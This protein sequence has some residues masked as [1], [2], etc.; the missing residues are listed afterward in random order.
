MPLTVISQLDLSSRLWFQHVRF[1]IATGDLKV[2][3]EVIGA[4][5]ADKLAFNRA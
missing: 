2:S 3:I 1:S 4:Q 5:I